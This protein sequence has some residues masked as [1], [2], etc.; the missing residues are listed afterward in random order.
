MPGRQVDV[1]AAEPGHGQHRDDG[2]GD[3]VL[4]DES[5]QRGPRHELLLGLLFVTPVARRLRR[6]FITIRSPRT[7]PG[8]SEFTRTPAG[9][10]ER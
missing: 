10:L 1:G 5:G 7:G 9:H 4:F 2:L 3:F 8:D 6:K